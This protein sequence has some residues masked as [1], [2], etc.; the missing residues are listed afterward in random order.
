MQKWAGMVLTG[1]LLEKCA[2]KYLLLEKKQ[3]KRRE[4]KGYK[5]KKLKW[6]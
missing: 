1:T 5:K 3:V 6:N 2:Q 4:R